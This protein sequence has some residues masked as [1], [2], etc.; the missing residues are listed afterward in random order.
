MYCWAY[1]EFQLFGMGC[2]RQ[3]SVMLKSY[4]KV[5]P[6]VS[7]KPLKVPWCFICQTKSPYVYIKWLKEHCILSTFT[8]NIPD[9]S[10]GSNRW[11]PC[12]IEM[13]LLQLSK[14]LRRHWARKRVW[15]STELPG[16]RQGFCAFNKWV[17]QTAITESP[18]MDLPRFSGRCVLSVVRKKKR[19]FSQ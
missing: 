10:W 17:T 14:F 13:K 3:K 4:Q 16:S 2:W 19:T 11:T 9:Q 7:C 5:F 18:V 8:E 15:R 12:S 6:S 1:L